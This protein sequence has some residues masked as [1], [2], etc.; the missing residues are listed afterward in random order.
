MVK[1]IRGITI[2]PGESLLIVCVKCD[3]VNHFDINL[4]EYGR[5]FA[6][7]EGTKLPKDCHNCGEPLVWFKEKITVAKS[8]HA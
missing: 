4:V 6:A 3:A 5:G 2:R 8:G 7:E 1:H